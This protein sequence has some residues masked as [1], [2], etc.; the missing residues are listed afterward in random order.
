LSF[1]EDNY[2][3]KDDDVAH[4]TWGEILTATRLPKVTLFAWVDSFTLLARRY[5]ETVKDKISKGRITKINRVAAKQITE[6]EKLIIATLNANF[7]AVKVHQGEYVFA[8]LV[9]LLAKNV[10][11]FIKRY[12]PQEH[13]RIMQYLKTRAKRQVIIQ[14][15]TSQLPKGKGKGQIKLKGK[16][17]K[18]QN[19]DRSKTTILDVFAGTGHKLNLA[20]TV[21]TS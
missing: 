13:P 16:K 5:A 19:N 1:I 9:K 14:T 8:E 11:S 20:R 2:V 6:D 15:F 3:E 17:Y 4:Y 21:S 7:T 18:I 12:T 10:T